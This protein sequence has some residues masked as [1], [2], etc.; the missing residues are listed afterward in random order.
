M[1]RPSSPFRITRKTSA[2]P[3]PYRLLKLKVHSDARICEKVIH[4][5]FR[6]LRIGEQFRVHWRA[7]NK[8]SLPL[9]IAKISRYV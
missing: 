4:E 6:G 5:R 7:D 9:R 3:K 2:S 8:T 1:R